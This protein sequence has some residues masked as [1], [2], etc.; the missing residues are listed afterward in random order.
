LQVYIQNNLIEIKTNGKKRIQKG[1]EKM[2]SSRLFITVLFVFLYFLPL[3]VRALDSGRPHGITSG[4]D[5]TVVSGDS[6][7]T[8]SGG[9]SSGS[10]LYY[11]FS[12]FNLHKGEQAIFTSG[13][14]INNIIGS[15][16]GGESSWI[17]GQITAGANLYLLNPSG[18]IFGPNTVLDVTG[19]LLVSTSDRILFD[20]HSFFSAI[21]GTSDIFPDS[22][23]IGVE[24]TESSSFAPIIIDNATLV[25]N[26]GQD[27]SL[28]GGENQPVSLITDLNDTSP[29]INIKNSHIQTPGGNIKIASVASAGTIRM[30][31][32]QLSE[33]TIETPGNIAVSDNTVIQTGG[34]QIDNSGHIYIYGGLFYGDDADVRTASK[35]NSGDIHMNASSMTLKNGCH[36]DSQSYGDGDGGDIQLQITNQLD[37]SESTIQTNVT[38]NDSGNA[39]HVVISANNM[40]FDNAS[41]IATETS[42]IGYAGQIELT[43]KDNITIT[44]GSEILSKSRGSATGNA[45]SIILNASKIRMNTSALISADTDGVGDAGNITIQGTELSLSDK[46]KISS[47]SNSSR[48]GGNAGNIDIQLTQALSMEGRETAIQTSSKGQGAAGAINI[49]SQNVYLDHEANIS[50]SGTGSE[51]YAGDAGA[52]RI[53]ADDTI[54]LQNK[55]QLSTLSNYAGGGSVNIESGRLLHLANSTINTSV[56]QG[57]GSGGDIFLKSQLVYINHSIVQAQAENGPGGNIQIQS[58]QF[59]E[60]SGNTISASSRLGIDGRVDIIQPTSDISVDVS[61]L[62]DQFIDDSAHLADVCAARFHNN[63]SIFSLEGKGALPTAYNDWIPGSEITYERPDIQFQ[64][65]PDRSQYLD[66]LCPFTDDEKNENS[67]E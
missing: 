62:P 53:F 14:E 48:Q 21:P 33:Q 8:I 50:S 27:L 44:G 56:L 57:W 18:F 5:Q 23:P 34:E 41:V 30:D 55:S 10:N 22:Q 1:I 7:Y 58:Q 65:I 54:R 67:S 43:A 39:G 25:L 59:L 19:S 64:H 24:F 51:N 17:N 49:S 61:Q 13:N 28:I 6:I 63:K 52:I 32:M 31:A 47:A 36:L 42:G 45:G 15:I 29:G 16:S 35:G 11:G 60:S 9:T 37:M 66:P 12:T 26:S 20:D 38:A 40:R 46:S 2:H 3:T 4:N